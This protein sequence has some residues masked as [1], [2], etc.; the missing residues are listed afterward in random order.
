[1]H[2]CM[3]SKLRILRC[4]DQVQCVTIRQ[5]AAHT[6][7]AVFVDSANPSANPHIGPTWVRNTK[8]QLAIDS[9]TKIMVQPISK[10]QQQQ[11]AG[12]H[13]VEPNPE[14]LTELCGERREVFKTKLP[15]RPKFSAVRV[16]AQPVGSIKMWD[17]QLLELYST[18]CDH[19]GPDVLIAPEDL[20]HSESFNTADD[21]NVHKRVSER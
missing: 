11:C 4:T 16:L 8:A 12:W 14:D 15:I 3:S 21:G 2:G 5:T 17:V 20:I 18:S 13:S 19:A 9:Q 1:V 7:D 6:S 10:I